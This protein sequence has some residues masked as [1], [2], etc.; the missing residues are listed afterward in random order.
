[1]TN[2][3]ALLADLR[4]NFEVLFKDEFKLSGPG[5]LFEATA[6][7]MDS[8]SPKDTF[9][10]LQGFPKVQKWLGERKLSD[11]KADK[12][13]V[14]NELYEATIRV[15]RTDI[16][17]DQP[18]LMYE[19]QIQQMPEEYNRARR[20]Q[21]AD[22]LADG[23]N[24]EAYDGAAFFSDNHPLLDG[25]TQ[26]N[27]TTGG[28]F[29]GDTMDTVIQKMEELKDEGGN[30]LDIA[31]DT[32]VMGPAQRA[33]ARNFFA[34]LGA[35]VQRSFDGENTPGINEYFGLI[36][37]SRVIIDPY[38]SGLDYYLV[39]TSYT[40]KPLVVSNRVA[41]QIEQQ[42][43]GSEHTFMKDEFL[44]GLRA[45]WGMSPAFW[46]VIHKVTVA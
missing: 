33:N 20:R 46:Q 24:M 2:Q 15:Q 31:P 19:R 38:L 5:R 43:E 7:E 11:F 34:D 40:L 29:D 22:M 27:V 45:R 16:E 30:I 39:D 18:F 17:D 9:T 10:M 8:N 12:I 35:G 41:P 37:P 26:S 36:D 14:V 25:D 6:M 1:M 32:I 28:A 4:E 13:E 44:Y 3:R 21:I 23:E 42:T